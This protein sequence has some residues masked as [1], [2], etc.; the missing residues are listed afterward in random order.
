M[1]SYSD[2]ESSLEIN[3][4]FLE[5]IRHIIYIY[6]YEQSLNPY[7]HILLDILILMDICVHAYIRACLFI[8]CGYTCMNMYLIVVHTYIHICILRICYLLY[9][10]RIHVQMRPLAHTGCKGHTKVLRNERYNIRQIYIH[11]LSE[12]LGD[13][14]YMFMGA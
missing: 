7:I 11:M 4:L 10:M 6:T 1:K 3:R 9:D 12:V 5:I 13:V 8:V 14:P 2:T